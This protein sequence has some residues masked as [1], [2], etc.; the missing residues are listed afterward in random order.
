MIKKIFKENYMYLIILVLL[1]LV[2]YFT[3]N[4][5]LGVRITEFDNTVFILK[6]KIVTNKLTNIFTTLTFVGDFYIP[7]IIIVCILMFKKKKANFG[8]LIFGYALSGLVTLISKNVIARPRPLNAFIDIPS[9]YSFPSGHTMT[10]F[11]F[12][13]TLCFLLTYNS[14]KN[15][16]YVSFIFSILFVLLIGFSRIYLGV[17]FLSDVLCGLLFGI[18]IF[19][20]IVNIVNKNYKERLK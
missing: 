10:S 7:F 20:M 15:I 13:I 5:K 16:K 2:F 6:D 1:I 11:V 17:H 12:Y 14:K 9:S 8:I 4:S 18:V 3:F 19:L